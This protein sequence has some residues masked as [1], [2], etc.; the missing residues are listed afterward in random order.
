[1]LGITASAHAVELG[2]VSIQGACNA[3][4]PGTTADV[5]QNNVYGWRCKTYWS[6]GPVY[7]SGIDLSRQCR[8]QYGSSAS[9]NY[10]NYNDPY[11]WRCYR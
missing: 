11:S 6:G 1:V 5:V 9:A 3:Q 10:T 8:A 7:Y 2:G 4:F